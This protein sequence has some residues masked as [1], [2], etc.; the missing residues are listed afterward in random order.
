MKI[1]IV[2]DSSL[3]Q[4]IIKDSLVQLGYSDFVFANDFESAL[5]VYDAQKPALVLL[6]IVM[7][8]RSGVEVLA[9]IRKKGNTPVIMITSISMQMFQ[10]ALQNLN[11]PRSEIKIEKPV[12]LT[13]PFTV[14]GLKSAL[15][16]AL[17][18]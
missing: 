10:E 12:Y 18:K 3:Q 4:K 14:D 1:L 8:G 17:Q 15:E 9:E 13:K 2:D 7:P 16:E 6:D 11:L 5:K